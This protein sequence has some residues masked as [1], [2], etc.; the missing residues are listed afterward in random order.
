M[1][2]SVNKSLRQKKIENFF[3]RILHK[4]YENTLVS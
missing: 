3:Y 2:A 1:F 4:V